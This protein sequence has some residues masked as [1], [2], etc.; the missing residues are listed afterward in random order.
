MIGNINRL[1]SAC[2][3]DGDEFAVHLEAVDML[4]GDSELHSVSTLSYIWTSIGWFVVAKVLLRKTNHLWINR[5]ALNT[6]VE[7]ELELM[8]NDPFIL[9]YLTCATKAPWNVRRKVTNF[10]DDQSYQTYHVASRNV[11]LNFLWHRERFW[12]PS[13]RMCFNVE[14]RGA[15]PYCSV[16]TPGPCPSGWACEFGFYRRVG[17]VFAIF[18]KFAHQMSKNCIG[19]S[20]L[21][22]VL[23]I[24]GL[25]SQS[26]YRIWECTRIILPTALVQLIV[27]VDVFCDW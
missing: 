1:V 20:L 21:V 15:K 26:A 10:R 9:W 23:A 16:N 4:N 22:D 8:S 7:R 12:S 5:D 27:D 19:I 24:L 14:A 18:D 25:Q 2:P 6:Y 17:R 13:N 3:F 11:E